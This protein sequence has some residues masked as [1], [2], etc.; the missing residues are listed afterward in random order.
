VLTLTGSGALGL[1]EA[2]YASD[3][4]S[5]VRAAMR[6]V[7]RTLIVWLVLLSLLVLAG[8]VG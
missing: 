6:L 5:P 8:W 4:V 2:A 3:A 7:W 1:D